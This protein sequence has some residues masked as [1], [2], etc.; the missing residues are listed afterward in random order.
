MLRLWLAPP[1]GRPL[2][3]AFAERY[4]TIEVGTRRGGITV[5]GVQLRVP[6]DPE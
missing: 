1:N 5:P 3:P 4:G 6:L 2:P